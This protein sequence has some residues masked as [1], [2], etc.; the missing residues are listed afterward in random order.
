[1]ISAVC[2]KNSHL[3]WQLASA[4]APKKQQPNMVYS[5]KYDGIRVEINN[6]IL[7]SRKGFRLPGN[8][9]PKW[10]R[11]CPHILDGELIMKANSSH[12]KVI[13]SLHRCDYKAMTLKIFDV[14]IPDI[15]FSDRLEIL[16]E[17]VPKSNRVLQ[18]PFED[19]T[20]I[21]DAMEECVQLDY[22]GLI[23]RSLAGMY[24]CGRQ[25][26]KNCYKLKVK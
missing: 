9:L 17:C 11:K 8:L 10:A 15:P 23:I 25:S 6:G 24:Q 14:K 21:L 26:N 2:T 18:I 4:V 13:K 12:T 3:C 7:L 22:E 16:E 1:M 20:E 5:I 19:D